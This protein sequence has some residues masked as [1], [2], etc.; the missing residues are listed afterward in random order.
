MSAGFVFQVIWNF[1]S[2]V[3]LVLNS[4][5]Y[6]HRE[7]LNNVTK[8]II[9]VNARAACFLKGKK[10]FLR[11]VLTKARLNTQR[12]LQMHFHSSVSSV[13]VGLQ[14]CWALPQ[15]TVQPLLCW[16]CRAAHL[17]DGSVWGIRPGADCSFLFIPFLFFFLQKTLAVLVP[18]TVSLQVGWAVQALDWC[19][20]KRPVSDCLNC[21]GTASSVPVQSCFCKISQEWLNTKI[22]MVSL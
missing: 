15:H 18:Q 9:A 21:H 12:S 10:N 11:G 16:H 20:S 5:S 2:F 17:L 3:F 8:V 7:V 19:G 6:V 14:C 1:L 13:S 22:L 4:L